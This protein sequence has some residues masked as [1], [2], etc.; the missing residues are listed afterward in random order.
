MRKLLTAL[1]ATVALLGVGAA[2]ASAAPSYSTMKANATW[3]N[4]YNCARYTGCSGQYV[5]PT[6]KL[7]T[8]GYAG[9][10]SCYTWYGIFTT[11]YYG[12]VC[13]T[14]KYNDYWGWPDSEHYE[15]FD[16]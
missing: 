11:R 9:T 16:C 1:V 15:Y 14:Y 6:P 13:T 5:N 12:Y 7:L 8:C 3:W 10:G 2:P 4:N